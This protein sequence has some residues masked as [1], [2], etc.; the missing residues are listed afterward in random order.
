MAFCTACGTALVPGSRFCIHCGA[1]HPGQNVVGQPASTEEPTAPVPPPIPGRAAQGDPNTSPENDTTW[2]THPE[3]ARAAEPTAALPAVTPEE[4]RP[5]ARRTDAGWPLT[6]PPQP[7]NDDPPGSADLHRP[8]PARGKKALIGALVLV[9]LFGG[10]IAAWTLGQPDPAASQATPT[11]TTTSSPTTSTPQSQ[12]RTST[13]T[14]STPVPTTVNPDNVQLTEDAASANAPA[15]LNLL[16]RYFDAANTHNY[17]AWVTTVTPNRAAGQPQT[18]WENAYRTTHDSSVVITAITSTG[19]D[20]ASAALSF[21]STQSTV[22]A[23][24]DLP[25]GRICWQ[26]QL[27]VSNLSG[28]GQ[29]GSSPP[30]A[31]TKR[32]C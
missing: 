25:V 10:G 30:G 15:V 27:P 11:A 9:I 3:A 28:G 18:S 23:P 19:P 14:T 22:D 20:S 6:P 21:T 29:V 32:A 17:P 16:Q 24:P 1:P 26:T 31:T 7:H 5:Q 12:S 4:T 8:P 2:L 13:P